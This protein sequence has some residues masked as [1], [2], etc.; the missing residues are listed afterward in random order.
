M[1]ALDMYAQAQQSLVVQNS[2]FSLK[3]VTDM[4][5][6]GSIDISPHYQ[7]RERW[8]AD[9][10]SALIES[11]LMNVPVPPVYLSEDDFGKYSVIDGKQ[12]ITAIHRFMSDRLKLKGMVKFRDLEGKVFSELPVEIKNALTVRPY[13]RIVTL[14]KQTNPDLK[15]EVFLRLNTG[16][17][18]LNSQEIRNVACTGS[19]ND[20]LYELSEYPVIKE[21]M[22]IVNKTSPNYRNMA[23]LELV[24]RFIT[25]RER[26]EH[27]HTS[28]LS[29]E[30]D[31]FMFSNKNATQNKIALIKAD[32]E[33]SL[34]L[35]IQIWGKSVFYKPNGDEWRTQ[36]I[37]PLFDAQM[38]A[39][40]L[41]TDQQSEAAVAN[42][43][44][45]VRSSRDLY[46]KDINY[47][48]AVD[49][50]TGNPQNIKRRISL[51]HN[52]ILNVIAE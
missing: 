12:R 18:R 49:R 48:N 36:M 35:C 30:M 45:I 28:L 15:Y 8:Q 19:L 9:K 42:A 41:L 33:R 4:V 38:L 21:R 1:K 26:W 14:L 43:L 37:A 17:E 3:T 23:D 16:G 44:K 13:L 6:G 51:L 20:L 29:N 27:M 46:L 40:H 47:K 10:Q 52:M 2:D 31:D 7:R 34:N 11:F 24:L 22:K 50:A 39:M 32:F 5:E 25:L